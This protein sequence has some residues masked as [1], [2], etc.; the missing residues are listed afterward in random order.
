MPS[1]QYQALPVEEKQDED[2]LNNPPPTRTWSK[3]RIAVGFS[4]LLLL[5]AIIAATTQALTRYIPAA[6]E[7]IE[8]DGTEWLREH[9][10]RT[11]GDKYLLGVGKADITG[12]VDIH[13]GLFDVC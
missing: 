3:T 8:E 11:T 9:L 4:L 12:F 10:T 1:Q 7:S 2:P 6:E 5:S 13:N